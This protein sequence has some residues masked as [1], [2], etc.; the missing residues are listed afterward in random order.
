MESALLYWHWIVLGIALMLSE[1]FLGSFF[2]F[3]FGAAAVVVGLLILPLPDMSLTAQLLIWAISSTS[4]VLA[5]FKLVKPLSADKTKAGLS[6]ETLLGEIGQV[7]LA[8]NGEKRGKLR[9]PA[10]VLGSDEWL[11]ISH[12]DLEVGDR[13]SVVELSGNALIVKKA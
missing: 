10:P 2:I 5:W 4:F 7:L 8:P 13:V 3:W 6:E 11:I 12:D 1:I 9:F